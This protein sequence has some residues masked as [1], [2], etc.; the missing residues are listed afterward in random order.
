MSPF[1]RLSSPLSIGYYSPTWPLGM[2]P[3]GIVTYVSILTE[4]LK[5]QGHKTTILADAVAEGYQDP[6]V[7]DLH[8]V[9]MSI[10]R[11]P[12][13]RAIYGLWR[14]LAAHPANSH[15]YRR[16][17]VSTLRRAIGARKIE[18]VEME[19]TYGWARWLQEATWVPVCVRLHGPW[20]QVGPA[21]GFAVDEGFRERVEQERRAI[22]NAAAVTAPSRDIL[23]KTRAFY[24]LEL[25]DA[26]V[27]A[28]PTEPATEHWRLD[29]ADP[30]RVLFIGRFDR[31]KGGDLVIDAFARVLQEVPEARLWFV[32]PDRGCGTNGRTWTIEEYVRDRLPDALE[33]KR[34]EWLGPQPFSALASLR[35]QAFV[36]VVCSV[37][38]TFPNTVIESLALGCPIVA[39]NVGGIPEIVR[40]DVNGLLH[41]ASDPVDL[42]SKIIRL[43]KAPKMAAALGQQG[44]IDCQRS[45]YPEVIA[46]RTVDFYRRVIERARARP[47]RDKDQPSK[48]GRIDS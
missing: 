13:N 19:E 42:A 5:L 30:R 14:R 10:S 41:R 23:E 44:A 2:F 39:A 20:F 11:K 45:Y 4:Q 7:Y 27:I 43:M 40:D 38:E 33:S 9:R 16:A 3:N 25:G 17:L 46:A 8:E 22:Q 6:T 36:S 18:I 34:V 1:D 12:V 35:R 24:G 31:L 28:N 47:K 32:G 15:L 48:T 21:L 26:E 29:R 37:Y